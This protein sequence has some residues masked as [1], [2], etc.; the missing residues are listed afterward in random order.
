MRHREE[1]EIDRESSEGEA[2]ASRD[3]AAMTHDLSSRIE[4]SEKYVDDT[5]EYRCVAR[6]LPPRELAQNRPRNA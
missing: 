4:Y 5:H 1:R 3:A 2:A 6:P